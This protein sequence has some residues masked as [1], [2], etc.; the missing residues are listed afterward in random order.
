MILTHLKNWRNIISYLQSYPKLKKRKRTLSQS[1][2]S[3]IMSVHLVLLTIH[4]RAKTL[5]L[6]SKGFM[7][8]GQTRGF[9]FHCSEGI[10]KTTITLL[11]IWCYVRSTDR[12]SQSF[13]IR[14]FSFLLDAYWNIF[15]LSIN[16]S[17]YL[18]RFY[19]SKQSQAHFTQVLPPQS[20][21]NL[22]QFCDKE[23]GSTASLR[24]RR[25]FFCLSLMRQSLQKL[26]RP[27][28]LHTFSLA[29]FCVIRRWSSFVRKC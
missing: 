3:G 26:S 23:C 1:W 4:L 17:I 22:C 18:T 9:W 19:G 12:N 16:L 11:S 25:R 20:P 10:W 29:L 13:S 5:E 7:S 14:T 24:S 15:Y 2:S 21:G 28:V 8:Q 27:E 6:H